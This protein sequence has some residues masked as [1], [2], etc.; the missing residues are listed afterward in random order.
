MRLN[1]KDDVSYTGDDTAACAVLGISTMPWSVTD[2]GELTDD[3]GSVLCSCEG[4][5]NR[6]R[7]ER[8]NDAL[9]CSAAPLLLRQLLRSQNML[10]RL[11]PYAK[12]D[13]AKTLEKENET[14]ISRL[15]SVLR[16][17]KINEHD[18]NEQGKEK[19]E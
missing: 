15:L 18:A 8:K 4:A 16:E 2:N 7:W 19:A 12:G 9:L 5:D 3:F 11:V 6:V 17:D 13:K 14:I 1:L 10:Q